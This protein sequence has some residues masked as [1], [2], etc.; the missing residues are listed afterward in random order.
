MKW[1]TVEQNPTDIKDK[2]SEHREIL[3]KQKRT[4]QP[5]PVFVGGP[6]KF[7]AYYV[8]LNEELFTVKR[9]IEAIEL[10]IHIAFALNAQYPAESKLVWQLF[11]KQIYNIE[12]ESDSG[13][14]Q[15]RRILSKIR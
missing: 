10:T 14:V 12:L 8:A 7:S 6:T 3:R 13:N 9:P 2:I 15:L 1:S 11:Q 5:T 4:F